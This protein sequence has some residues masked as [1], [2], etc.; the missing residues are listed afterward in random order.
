MQ[1]NI[2]NK[3]LAKAMRILECFQKKP[4]LGVTEIAEMTELN[5]SNVHDHLMTLTAL[6]YVRQDPITAKYGLGYR[7]LEL[8]HALTASM[9]FR[10]TVYPVIQRLSDETGEVVYYGIPDGGEV[11]YLDAAYPSARLQNSR[12]ML[13]VRAEMYCTAI[14][15]ALLSRYPREEQ[16]RI[17]QSP[18][19]A[20]T[21][22]TLIRPEDILQE[23]DC[24]R[25]QGYAV[26]NMEHEYG[27]KCVGVVIPAPDGR[28]QAAIS[29]SGPSLRFSDERIPQLAENLFHAVEELRYFL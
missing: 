2:K 8:S 14:G 23:L 4:S 21:P 1:N 29:I 25:H 9:G 7:I 3:S 27:I 10:R 16:L 17:L 24:I 6:G 15:K 28:P 19:T 18:R 22:N 11:L 13:G 12:G 20:Y 26:D 5:K